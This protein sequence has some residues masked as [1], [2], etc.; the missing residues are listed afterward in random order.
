MCVYVWLMHFAIQLKVTQHYKAV[1][2]KVNLKR[3]K[4][5]KLHWFWKQF[6]SG[7]QTSPKW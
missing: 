3:K 4:Q 2:T 5:G 1:L 6:P 7:E